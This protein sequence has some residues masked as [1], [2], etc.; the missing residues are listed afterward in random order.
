MTAVPLRSLATLVTGGC[1]IAGLAGCGDRGNGQPVGTTSQRP[2]PLQSSA[3]RPADLSY[4]LRYQGALD[5]RTVVDTS[6]RK[7]PGTVIAGGG[8]G[9]DAEQQ[10]G[11]AAD[12][13]AQAFLRFPA[14]PCSQP[15]GCPQAMIQP[16]RPVNPGAAGT[17]AFSF[18]A[19]VRLRAAPGEAG[20][21]LIE[22]GRAI[23]GQPQWKLQVDHGEAS[24]RWSDG[25]TSLLLPDDLDESFP[26]EQGRWYDLQCD[27]RAGG[28]FA[29][30]VRDP[31]S[32]Q[33]LAEFSKPVSAI[34]AIAPKGPVSIGA[35]RVGG[36]DLQ[37]DQFR[38]D[39]DDVFFHTE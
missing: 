9:V 20:Q 22:R 2:G 13:Q 38:G 28:L 18:G 29:L 25:Q 36:P 17:A 31:A 7:N 3:G 12:P 8:G 24:C 11:A 6:G 35:K 1:L 27:R 23:A 4:E 19:R 26:M 33:Q 10:D 16:A 30:V 37:T 39:L 15:S 5:G 21:N 14:D 34:G 32:G